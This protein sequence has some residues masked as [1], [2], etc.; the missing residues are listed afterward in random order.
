MTSFKWK[1]L[2]SFVAG[3]EAPLLE[4]TESEMKIQNFS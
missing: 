4:K 3:E 2:V 1:L